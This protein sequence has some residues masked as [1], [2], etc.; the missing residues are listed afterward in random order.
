[1]EKVRYGIIGLG[2][3]GTMY[4]VHLFAKDKIKDGYITA[5]CDINPAKIEYSKKT[6]KDE[7]ITYFTDYIEMLDSGLVDAVLVETPHYFHPEMVMECLKRGIHAVCEKPAGVY[8]KQVREMNEAAAKSNALFGMMFNQRTNCLYRKMKEMIASGAIGEL[9]RVTW[10]ITD[11]F[12]TQ[13]YY[14][15]GSWRATWSGEGGGVLFNQCPH[16]IDLVQWIVG[17]LPASV[18]AFCQYGKWHNIE[19]EDEVTAFFRFKN[20]ATG[21]FI[22]TTGE[23]P[24][25]NRLE[26]SG[27][28]GKLLCENNELVWYKNEEDSQAYSKV[29]KDGFRPP[30]KE[31]IKVETD[32]ENPQHAGIIN[33]FTQAILG[34]E[35]LFVLGTDGI[36]G[37]ELTNAISL[38]GWLGGKEVTLPVDEDLYLAELTKRC[39]TSAKKEGSDAT[40]MD[41]TA[42][43]GSSFNK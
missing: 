18:N 31:I 28:K 22:T 42:S 2:N 25:S 3:Q 19:V 41:T 12:R 43:T 36:A 14:D 27:T 6:L 37:V 9:Q 4:S 8:T 33:N 23:A 35:N 7:S 29:A 40:V 39:E 11:W 32:G 5:L 15:S 10:I 38:S 1:M 34:K 20:G 16:Q 21:V 26:I 13:S 24:G 17:E 30:N